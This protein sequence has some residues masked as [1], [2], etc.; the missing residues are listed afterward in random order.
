[1][2]QSKVSKSNN[3]INST[4]VI[5]VTLLVVITALLIYLLIVSNGVGASGKFH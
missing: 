5:I 3:A 4:H 2:A 1:M